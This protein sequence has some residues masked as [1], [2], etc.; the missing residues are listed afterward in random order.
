[1]NGSQYIKCTILISI[2]LLTFTTPVKPLEITTD[3]WMRI[4]RGKNDELGQAITID[5][6]GDMI[7]SG[8]IDKSNPLIA[9]LF[10][11]M[12]F[13]DD[14]NIRFI[15][16][17][18]GDSDLKWVHIWE[19]DGF[20][21]SIVLES[22]KDRNIYLAGQYEKYLKFHDPQMDLIVHDEYFHGVYLCKFS[23][24]G[25]LQWIDEW[26][27]FNHDWGFRAEFPQLDI[28][29]DELG[30]IY[31]CGNDAFI[32]KYVFVGIIKHSFH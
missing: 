5:N 25:T 27:G 13:I 26:Q 2:F 32:R 11:E 1:M 10:D 17:Y 22:D 19:N 31:V 16:K 29:S 20:F 28:S 9:G 7:V 15:A 3:S 4:Y 18:S 12:D 6:S 21:P 24:D 14:S 30:N 8:Q 23:P